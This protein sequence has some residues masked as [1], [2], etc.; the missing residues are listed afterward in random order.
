VSNQESA[1]NSHNWKSK[2]LKWAGYIVPTVLI[3]TAIV[4]LYKKLKTI[5]WE[6]VGDVMAETSGA[7]IA[8]AAL[9]VVAAYFTLTFYDY[10]ATRQIGRDDIPYNKT[11]LASFTS[12]SIAHNLGAT[13]F[14]AA[15]VR[16]LIYSRYGF[17]AAEVIKVCV[18][19]GLTF[20]LGNATVLGLGFALE[21][22]AIAPIVANVGLGK[23]FIQYT[24]YAILTALVVY[25]A[26]MQRQNRTIGKGD[27]AITLPNGKNTALQIGIGIV[28]LSFCAA[29]MYFLLPKGIDAVPFRE[30]MVIFVTAMLLGFASHAPG[31]VGAFEASMLLALPDYEPE[32]VVAAIILFRLFYFIIP[33]LIALA[34]IVTRELRSGGLTALKDSMQEIKGANKDK[35]ASK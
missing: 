3:V 9:C 7:S 2:A 32:E 20:W 25:I 33:F 15:V 19:A 14:T 28:D 5:S 16:Y 11:A 22:E 26:L 21:P 31:G 4:V 24:G 8:A 13:M 34:L 1:S 18:L 10:F 27:W 35:K 17:S 6:Q 29:A 23:Q 30:L 12:Y